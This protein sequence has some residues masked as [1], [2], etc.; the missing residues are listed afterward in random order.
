MKVYLIYRLCLA[1]SCLSPGDKGSP[2]QVQTPVSTSAN[3]RQPSQETYLFE[4]DNVL[5]ITLAGNLKELLN[6]RT[7]N[8]KSYPLVLSYNKTGGSEIKLPVAVKTRGH[9]RKIKGNCDYPPLLIQ[10]PKK[11]GQPSSI[12]SEQSRLKLVMP[13]R[14]DE[15]IVR[16]WLLYRIYNLVTPLSFRTRLVKVQLE[17]DR[18]KKQP[19]PFYGILLEEEK[20]MAK[21]NSCIPVV[22]RLQPEKIQPEAFLT[23]AVFQYLVGNTDW[24]VQY[25][26]NIKLIANDSGATPLPVP[27]DFDHAGMVDCPYAHPAE[28]LKMVSV[29]ERRYRGYCVHNQ[30]LFEPVIAHYNRLKKDIYS[31]YS[32]CD[33]LEPKYKKWVKQYLDQFYAIINNAKTWKREFAYPCDPKGTGN[34]VIK[35][36]KN[37]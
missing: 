26:Q 12:F 33:L 3:I 24:S 16:E 9:F 4:T 10:F 17:D 28:L 8:P 35:G 37:D 30:Q 25:L 2:A 19:P 5:H 34:V 23:L 6:D 22:K 27:Y 32:D 11:A 31:L 20:Q 29:R 21:R 15:Y 7:D 1:F 13:C 14:G 36:L 18:N